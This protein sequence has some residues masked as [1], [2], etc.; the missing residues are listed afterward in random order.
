[1]QA[2]YVIPLRRPA[3]SLY[4]QDTSRLNQ[5]W[6]TPQTFVAQVGTPLHRVMLIV[7]PLIQSR[8]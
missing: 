4:H 8:K 6:I 3:C 1:M 7:R 5:T 2:F